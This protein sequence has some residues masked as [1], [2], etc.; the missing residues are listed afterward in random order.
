MT[1]TLTRG[2]EGLEIA[3]L[4]ALE[5]DSTPSPYF[6]S[7]PASLAQRVPRTVP[8]GR[9]IDRQDTQIR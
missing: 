7:T 4:L 3:R 1:A 9:P 6:P 8:L 5:V 2:D